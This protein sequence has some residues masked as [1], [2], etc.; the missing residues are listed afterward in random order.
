MHLPIS[1]CIPVLST[2]S[3]Y[4]QKAEEDNTILEKLT[5]KRIYLIL[6][7]F[8]HMLWPVA[9]ALHQGADTLLILMNTYGKQYWQEATQICGFFPPPIDI[10]LS[11]NFLLRY[12]P[13]LFKNSSLR[14]SLIVTVYSH[15]SPGNSL[16]GAPLRGEANWRQTCSRAAG[17]SLSRNE[18]L[19]TERHPKI[20]LPVPS[21]PWLLPDTCRSHKFPLLLSSEAAS[22][23]RKQ[24]Q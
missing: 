6:W 22:L 10:F 7:Y 11:S 12:I 13:S 1:C 4:K 24:I 19:L 5:G 18:K 14:S 8:R 2:L 20:P 17:C 15:N 3:Q 16:H 21:S 23:I 9:K